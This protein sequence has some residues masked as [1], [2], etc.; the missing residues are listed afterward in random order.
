MTKKSAKNAVITVSGYDIS[1]SV[2]SY[3][4][5]NA[6]KAED[7]TGFGDGVNNFILGQQDHQQTA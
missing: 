5:V 7:A 1:T 4:I 3:E 2:Q 6:Y